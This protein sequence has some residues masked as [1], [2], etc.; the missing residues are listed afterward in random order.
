V[1]GLESALADYLQL[2]RQLGFTLDR[3]ARWLASFADYAEARGAGYVTT[4][5]ALAWAAQP[6]GADRSW[7]AAR[8]SAVRL[9]ARYL[10]ARDPRTEVPA[11]GLLPGG[12]R[13]AEPYLYSAAEI[14]A[15]MTAAGA[16]RAPLRAATYQTLIGLLAVTGMRVGE[17]ISLDR[18]HADLDAGV[19]TVRQG[20]FGKSR[21]LPLHPS[22]VTALDAYARIR[23]EAFPRPGTPAFFASLAGTRL[24]Y[25]NVHR[26]YH[27]L[28][29]AAGLRPRSARCRPRIHDLRHSFAV[30]TLIGWYRDG[31]DVAARLP[32]LSTYLGHAGPDDTY[33]YLEAAPELLTLAAARLGTIG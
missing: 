11:A 23:D 29:L 6:P 28:T 5:L 20:K 27:R 13:R 10:Q 32:L 7:H 3:P 33:W 4:E 26:T 17:A 1:T 9:F 22:A 8:L 31:G 21:Q 16:I 30:A 24:I 14:T 15:L 12:S 19:I 2:R 18:C 25:K